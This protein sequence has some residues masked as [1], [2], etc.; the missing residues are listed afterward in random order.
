MSNINKINFEISKLNNHLK[1]EKIAYDI[2]NEKLSKK[3]KFS[4]FDTQ[5]IINFQKVISDIE[6]KIQLL[7]LNRR[8]YGSNGNVIIDHQVR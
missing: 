5:R 2:L 7:K 1:K 6:K 8:E 4:N 3:T